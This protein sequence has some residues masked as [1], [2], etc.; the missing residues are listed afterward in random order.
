MILLNLTEKKR[1][2][3]QEGN[4]TKKEGNLTR[5]GTSTK[6]RGARPQRR[7]VDHEG[8]ELDQREEGRRGTR[9]LRRGTGP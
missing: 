1:E 9:H 3:F 6:R 7:E 4:S 8:G 2:K 5:R